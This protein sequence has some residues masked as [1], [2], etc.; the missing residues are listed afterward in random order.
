MRVRSYFGKSAATPPAELGT[1]CAPLKPF[2]TLPKP[3]PKNQQ[4][5]PADPLELW[6]A[7]PFAPHLDALDGHFYGRGVD[8]DKGGLLTAVHAIEA[9]LAANGASLAF[10]TFLGVSGAVAQR[11][12]GAL[13]EMREGGRVPPG[14]ACAVRPT[15]ENP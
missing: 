3:S 5:Q 4:V 13:G 6:A 10:A 15:P 7:P 2:K 14:R 8:D 1:P 12:R 11:R 9:M